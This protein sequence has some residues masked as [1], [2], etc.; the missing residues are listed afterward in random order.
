MKSGQNRD[1][2]GMKSGQ[3][4]DEIGT[5]TGQKCQAINVKQCQVTSSNVKE[6]KDTKN[7]KGG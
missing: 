1:E 5:K 7:K 2:I 6:K 4:R 3:N